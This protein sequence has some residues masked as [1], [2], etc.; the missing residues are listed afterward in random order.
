MGRVLKFPNR[1]VEPAIPFRHWGAICLGELYPNIPVKAFHMLQ[2]LFNLCVGYGSFHRSWPMSTENW[3]ESLRL[4]P[5]EVVA[6]GDYLS[7]EIGLVYWLAAEDK[8]DERL[9][10]GFTPKAKALINSFYTE[11]KKEHAA[12]Q[13]NLEQFAKDHSVFIDKYLQQL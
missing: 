2:G 5:E 1:D 11:W 13:L 8:P 12:G 7:K 6:C 10:Y 9:H 3:Y 4:S